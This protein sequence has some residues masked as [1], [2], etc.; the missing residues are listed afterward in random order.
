MKKNQVENL[1]IKNISI[2]FS[3]LNKYIVKTEHT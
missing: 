3:N 2:K 1:E